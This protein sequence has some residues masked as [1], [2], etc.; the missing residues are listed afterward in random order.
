MR[1][2]MKEFPVKDVQWGKRVSYN[3]GVLEINKEQLMSIALEDK[4]ISAADL[5]VA[6][7]GEK[8][9][10]TFIR[11][12]VEPRVKVSGPGCVFP[13]IL[14]P[15][16]T[17]GSGV[18]HRMS[19]VTVMPSV[20]YHSASSPGLTE[21]APGLVD[22]SG[23]VAQLSPYGSLINIVLILKL[24]DGLTELEAHSTIQRAELKIAQRLAE[25]VKHQTT[26]NVEVFE[27]CEVHSSLPRIVYNICY[28]SERLAPHSGV[29]LYGLPVRESLPFMIHPNELF[30]GA[31]TPDARQGGRGNP[32]TWLWMNSPMILRLFKE[33]GKR[34]NFLG[35]I[36]QRSN[37]D[38]VPARQATAACTS[39]MARLLKADGAVITSMAGV[40]NTFVGAM[41]TTQ[42]YEKK[43]IKTVFMTPQQGGGEG[44]PPLAFYTAEANA[45]ICT[46][47]ILNTQKLPKPAKVIGSERGQM[48]A[49]QSGEPPFDP[50]GEPIIDKLYGI[51]GAIDWWGRSSYSCKE[52]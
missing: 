33:H 27:L 25:T 17:V 4:K 50:W 2:E 19:G 34:L 35:I 22:M 32:Q 40:G 46:G 49:W 29:A 10:I 23:P 38:S 5:D 16:E 44:G 41:L 8:T 52:Y 12:V 47:D 9:R 51:A 6:F 31:V 7:P 14:G 42:A 21:G 45:M 39:Q 36:M 20:Q 3:G 24:V 26:E 13:G 30:D 43:G 1:L 48:Q 15:V 28:I 37:F 11:D 18:T